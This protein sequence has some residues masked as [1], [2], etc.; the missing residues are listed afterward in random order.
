[1]ATY[2]DDISGS[3]GGSAP[4]GW[5]SRW[6]DQVV[7]TDTAGALGYLGGKAI[8][9]TITSGLSFLSFDAVDGDGSRADCDVLCR[10]S[11]GASA[12]SFTSGLYVRGSGTSTTKNG[13]LL[14]RNGA[15]TLRL[16]SFLNNASNNIATAT[17]DMRMD[18]EW[19]WMRMRANG[20][21]ISGK[22]WRCDAVEPA[23]WQISVTNTTVSAA[24]WIGVHTQDNARD[25]YY[26]DAISVGTAGDVAPMPAITSGQLRV[27][28][29]YMEVLASTVLTASTTSPYVAV[30][31]N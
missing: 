23:D 24:G 14:I 15:N 18:V 3:T 25:P 6:G 21:T 27:T 28:S 19:T 12:G 10:M 13:Y 26:V 7:T 5:T 31:V 16:Y 17:I 4:T 2:Y 20:S 22:V 29:N 8:G 11:D 1:M 30:C 9:I